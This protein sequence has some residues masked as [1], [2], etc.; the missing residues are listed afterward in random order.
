M[1]KSS[2]SI[3]KALVAGAAATA[4]TYAVLRACGIAEH[5]S[6]LTGMPLSPASWVWGP[7]YVALHALTMI[8]VPIVVLAVA[9]D[10]AGARLFA[11]LRARR[12]SDA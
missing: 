5:T 4:A 1:S 12:K 8:A 3:R 6:V 9:F 10:W 7:L 2:L 11:A